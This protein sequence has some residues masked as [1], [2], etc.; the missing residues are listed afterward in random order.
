MELKMNLT[1]MAAILLAV[2]VLG[3]ADQAGLGKP[4]IKDTTS[5][6]GN[7]TSSTSEII[8]KVDVYNPNPV[9]LPLKD[10]LT[11]VYMNDIKMG[12]GSAVK[13]QIDANSNSTILIST[14]IKNN[15]ISEWWVS[16]IED[17]E[18]SNMSM[19]GDLVFDLRVTEFEYPIE[20]TK[21]IKTDILG[22]INVEPQEIDSP[23]SGSISIESG[24]FRWEEVNEDSTELVATI[25]LRNN[26]PEDTSILQVDYTV[27]MN[28]I[29][30]AEK[31]NNV[32]EVIEPDSV[33][34]LTYTAEI[35]NNKLDEWWVTHIENNE[36][37]KIDVVMQAVAKTSGQQFEF[38]LVNQQT[39]FKTNLME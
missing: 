26:N 30:V 23:G 7:V 27:K 33:A 16:H 8:T 24:K 18:A 11:K 10:V 14:E 36:Q 20:K 29:K 38:D 34:E 17:K 13:S 39:Q 5:E 2:T 19:K 32:T 28:D 6:W 31:T 37:S 25:N 3:C 21:E 9:P 22:G 15:R 4:E 1:L 12:E 35:N